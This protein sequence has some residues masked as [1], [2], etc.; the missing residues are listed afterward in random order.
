M[1]G[2]TNNKD[3]TKKRW[4]HGRTVQ[5]GKLR[6]LSVSSIEKGDSSKPTG[7]LRKWW[8][9]YLGGL[10]EE[11]SDAMAKGERLHAEIAHYL[12]TGENILSSQVMA[13]L[14]MIPEPG[15]DLLVEHDIVPVMPNGKSGIEIAPLRANGVP[16]V[17]AIDLIHKRGTNK[18]TDNIEE[19]YDPKGTIEVIDWKSCRT[20]ANAKRGSELLKSIQMAGYGKYIFETN[21]QAELVRLSHGYFPSQGVPKKTTIRVDRDQIDKAWEHANR[22][23]SSI[24]DAA[25]ETNPDLVEANTEACISYGRECPAISVCEAAKSR[26]TNKFTLI[27]AES[28][29][30]NMSVF[31]QIKKG[32]TAPAPVAKSIFNKEA[33][34]PDELPPFSGSPSTGVTEG[35]D[36]VAKLKAEIAKLEAHERAVKGMPELLPPDAPESNPILASLPKVKNEFTEA[37]AAQVETVSKQMVEEAPPAP[38]K[39]GRKPKAVPEPTP[40]PAPEVIPE[41]PPVVTEPEPEPAPAEDPIAIPTPGK[42]NFYVDCTPES[43]CES[44][45]PVVDEIMRQMC[46]EAGVQDIRLSVDPRFD[47]GRWKGVLA[48]GIYQTDLGEGNWGLLHAQSDV[49]QV[50]VEVMRN[51]ARKSGGEVV[52]GAR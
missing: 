23:A 34:N 36:K 46:N 52:M 14:H 35:S 20:L 30:K 19:M 12:T 48:K 27:P 2:A 49:A 38:K 51:I 6:F 22:V 15:D 3:G 9:Q 37:L 41:P 32:T 33:A 13:G 26:N 1:S 24:G 28:L 11:G 8:Y 5:D 44:L 39:R 29:T 43:G 16:I 4:I 10:K 7:C 31:S 25:K 18:G 21:P 17:G 42:I 50:V 40:E 45:W 47:F